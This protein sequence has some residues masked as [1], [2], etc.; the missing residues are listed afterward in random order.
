[1]G[2]TCGQEMEASGYGKRHFECSQSRHELAG[3]I[4]NLRTWAILLACR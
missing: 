4:P 2:L 1:M 3:H